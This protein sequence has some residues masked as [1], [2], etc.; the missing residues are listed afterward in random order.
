MSDAA[1]TRLRDILLRETVSWCVASSSY[2]RKRFPPP[3]AFRGLQ[4]L[5]SLPVLTRAEVVENHA[6]LLCDASLPTAIQHTTGTTGAF[7]ELYRGAAEQAFIWDFFSAQLQTRDLPEVRPLH[8]NLTN[9]YHGALTAM[10]SHAYVLSAGVYDR[11]QAQQARG[12]LERTYELPGVEP[13]V[14]LLMGTERMVKALTAYLREDGFDL[15]GSPVT[16]VVLFGGHVS[17]RHKL[18][19]GQAWGAAIRDVYSLTEIFGGATEVGIG[20]PWVF[21]PHVVPEVVHPRTFEP[22]REGIGV[23]LLTSLYPFTQQMPLV[24]YLTNDLVE[25]VAPDDDPDGLRV[26]YMGRVPR[27][28]VDD[29]GSDVVPLLLSAPLY[30][31]LQTFPDVAVTPRFPDLGAQSSLELTG[32]HHYAVEHTR[33]RKRDTITIRLG[34]RYSPW[35]YPERVA[36]LTADATARVLAAH[37]ALATRVVAGRADVRV[38]A[39]P[40]SAV[41]TYDSK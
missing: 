15:A 36:A 3:G 30:E 12:L 17:P 1:A 9:A 40:A 26:R 31:I 33:T 39:E 35:L 2:Y 27:S 34:L 14:S 5:A 20:G 29:T 23:L 24:R 38:V 8:L 13:R 16:T 28:V 19:L 7:L 4:D 41:G 6:D 21:D 37:P 18:L 10:P 32:D 25:V 22:I 11:A